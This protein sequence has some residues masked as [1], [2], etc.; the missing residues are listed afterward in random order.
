MFCPLGVIVLI[1]FFIILLSEIIEKSFHLPPHAS[2]HL[3]FI[4]IIVF[5]CGVDVFH[6]HQFDP[7]DVGLQ[8]LNN[9]HVTH[10]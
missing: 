2:R 7:N 6:S 1:L 10:R 9:L 5:P 8:D 3:I 4:L